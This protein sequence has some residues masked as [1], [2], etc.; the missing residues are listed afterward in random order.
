MPS[1]DNSFNNSIDFLER[2]SHK[3]VETEGSLTS[4]NSNEV[5]GAVPDWV[6]ASTFTNYA[7]EKEFPDV[8]LKLHSYNKN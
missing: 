6:D 2:T 1:F 4:G 3:Y 5:M 8:A 7:G